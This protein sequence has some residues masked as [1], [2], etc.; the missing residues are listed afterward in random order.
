M[1]AGEHGLT[2]GTCFVASR[3]EV[4]A[5]AGLLRISW[6]VLG[7]AGYFRVF[8]FRFIFFKRT[9]PAASMR[10]PCLIYLST[11][12]P[13][14]FAKS[15]CISRPIFFSDR[16]IKIRSSESDRIINGLNLIF[17]AILAKR[18]NLNLDLHHG[19]LQKFGGFDVGSSFFV[20]MWLL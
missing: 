5:V 7:A 3:L 19:W 13:S 11:S 18:G 20:L 16:N 9:R 2:R 15:D 17:W 14:D 1:E 12:I 10:P 6:C 8:A 4:V